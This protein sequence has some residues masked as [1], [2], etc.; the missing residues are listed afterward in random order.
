M[1]PDD[2]MGTFRGIKNALLPCVLFWGLLA[3]WLL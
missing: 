3:W 2:G 1:T